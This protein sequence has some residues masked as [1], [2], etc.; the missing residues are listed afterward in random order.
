MLFK[1]NE[2]GDLDR[3]D[4]LGK[5]GFGG[6]GQAELALPAG[7][8]G[9]DG[10]VAFAHRR[11]FTHGQLHGWVIAHFVGGVNH[12]AGGETFP[13]A[14]GVPMDGAAV[15]GGDRNL[16]WVLGGVVGADF[17]FALAAGGEKE[18]AEDQDEAMGLHGIQEC[19]RPHQ[20]YPRKRRALARCGG[21][22]HLFHKRFGAD[23]QCGEAMQLG[24]GMSPGDRGEAHLLCTQ[25]IEQLFASPAGV[26]RHLGEKTAG[27]VAVGEVNAVLAGI[28]IEGRFGGVEGGEDAQFEIERGE[29][30]EHDG[31]HEEAWIFEDGLGHDRDGL[32]ERALGVEAADAAAQAVG[33]QLVEGDEAT[34]GLVQLGIFGQARGGMGGEG[35]ADG[36]ARQVE[37]QGLLFGREVHV[38]TVEKCAQSHD[39][40]GQE[41]PH[42]AMRDR[43]ECLPHQRQRLSA[44]TVYHSRDRLEL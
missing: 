30:A 9:E 35:T 15:V 19:S 29:I 13:I 34:G 18:S 33:A 39:F 24:L 40:G 7:D 11:D 25:S 41:W 43:Q 28:E 21:M 38:V 44:S 2:A 22:S 5:I 31:I 42:S 4:E 32:R 23:Q 20:K 26:P 14:R 1:C 17:F 12:L 3:C 36:V 27:S 10:G 8:V 6:W 37:E 16:R